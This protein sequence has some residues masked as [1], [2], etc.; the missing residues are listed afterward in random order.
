[1]EGQNN[2]SQSKKRKRKNLYQN[3]NPRFLSMFLYR[4]YSAAIQCRSRIWSLHRTAWTAPPSIDVE[5]HSMIPSETTVNSV[6]RDSS[7]LIY[8]YNKRKLSWETVTSTFIAETTVTRSKVWLSYYFLAA[9]EQNKLKK[10][11]KE[12]NGLL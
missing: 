7:T 6:N 2:K 8:Y 10:K 4:G 5:N 3:D 12:V 11:K 1:M 9:K